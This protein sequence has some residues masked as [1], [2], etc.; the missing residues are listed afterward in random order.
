[1]KRRVRNLPKQCRL[2]DTSQT[3]LT[4]LHCVITCWNSMHQPWSISPISLKGE[5]GNILVCIFSFNCTFQFRNSQQSCIGYVKI[6]QREN[7][8]NVC[9]NILTHIFCY[10]LRRQFFFLLEEAL[11]NF[12]FLKKGFRFFFGLQYDVTWCH[13]TNFGAIG[14]WN[15]WCGMC[16]SAGTFSLTLILPTYRA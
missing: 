13:I 7:S 11:P 1:M 10:Y 8:W 15:V 16:V 14:L 3:C 2:L 4:T 5:S 9:T 6:S 12:V